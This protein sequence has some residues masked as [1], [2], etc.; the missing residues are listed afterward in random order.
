MKKTIYTPDEA[1]EKLDN[2]EAILVDV[3]DVARA[4]TVLDR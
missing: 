1:K 4:L 3:R 2:G